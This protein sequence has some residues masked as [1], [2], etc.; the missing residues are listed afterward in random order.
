M[1]VLII[2]L[3]KKKMYNIY[4]SKLKLAEYFV[5]INTGRYWDFLS[6]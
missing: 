5:K 4:F 6:I 2:L 1:Y 3:K